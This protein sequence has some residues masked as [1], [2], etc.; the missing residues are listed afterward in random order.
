MTERALGI[1]AL[2]SP[3]TESRSAAN[4]CGKLSPGKNAPPACNNCRRGIPSQTVRARPEMVS[5]VGGP[6]GLQSQS[7]VSGQPNFLL[8]QL[9]YV[10]AES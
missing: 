6:F 4:N 5:I 7:V 2:D 3:A 1:T 10:L 9:N 8:G